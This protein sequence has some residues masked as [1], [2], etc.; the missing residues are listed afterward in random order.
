MTA[1]AYW[2]GAAQAGRGMPVCLSDVEAV[3]RDVLS[4]PVWDFLTGGAGEEATLRANIAAFDAVRLR[5]RILTG[6]SEP[7]TSVTP[8]GSRWAVPFGIAPMACHRLV[9]P[10]GELATVRAAGAAGV[11]TVVSMLA[12][13]TIEDIAS[14]ASEPLWL[15]LFRTRDRGLMTSLVRRAEDAG[16]AAVVLTADMP[17]M[18]RR[19]RDM[20]NGFH[21]PPEYGPVNLGAMGTQHA[22]T[23]GE[24]GVHEHAK[25]TFDPGANWADVAWLCALTSLPVLVKGVLTREDAELAVSCGARGVVVSNHGGRQL[26]GC[27]AALTALPEVT[28]AVGGRVPVLLD[29]GIRRGRDV[30]AALAAGATAVLVGRPVLWGLADGEAGVHDVLSLLRAELVE[31]MLLC[32]VGSAARVRPDVL[33][34]AGQ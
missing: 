28:A 2:S 4:A 11:A 17:V 13:H 24:S 29:G 16:Y 31:A 9:H 26:D 23:R 1:A 34:G 27:V 30:L 7:D 14:A 20:R 32:G 19:P 5:P 15:Q 8:T 21:I 33:A 25:R 10:S 18:A 22:G 3:A 6:V 12:S